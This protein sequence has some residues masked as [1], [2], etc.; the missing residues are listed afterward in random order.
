[1]LGWFNKKHK[2]DSNDKKIPDYSLY[3]V[4]NKIVAGNRTAILKDGGESLKQATE[5]DYVFSTVYSMKDKPLSKQ[6][7]IFCGNVCRKLV[8]SFL[9]FKFPKQRADL[10]SLLMSALPEKKCYVIH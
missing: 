9:S 10:A 8:E 7:S 1:M 5:Y 2:K 4:E 3:R 6:E